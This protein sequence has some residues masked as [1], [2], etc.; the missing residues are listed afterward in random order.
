MKT[1][2]IALGALALAATAAQAEPVPPTA[3]LG[4]AKSSA[5]DRD[6]RTVGSVRSAKPRAVQLRERTA[7][8]VTAHRNIQ[9]EVD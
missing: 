6:V 8:P 2:A 5:A 9:D 3:M 7:P 4:F 1:F